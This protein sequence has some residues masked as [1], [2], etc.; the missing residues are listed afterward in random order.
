MIQRE[1]SILGHKKER[2]I[3]GGL[4]IIHKMMVGKKIRDN[5]E[6]KKTD[7]KSSLIRLEYETH[8]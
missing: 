6:S 7:T 2:I 5:R 8:H 4:Y 1:L 3:G